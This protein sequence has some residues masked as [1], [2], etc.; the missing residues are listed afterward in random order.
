[1]PH[2]VHFG[3]FDLDLEAAELR[4]N[5][6]KL[7]LPEQQFQ[8]LH[9]LL[10]EEGGV[11]S[12]DEIRK[13]LWPNDTVVEFDRSINAAVMKLRIALGDTGDK[14]RYIETLV[15]RGYRLMV[16]VERAHGTAAERPVAAL[17]VPGPPV[18]GPPVAGPRHSSLVGCKVSHYRVL[19]VLG[20][21]G[22]GLV[23][24]GED[25]KLNRPVALKFLPDEMASD[26]LTVQ[27]FEREA[28]TA[29]SL[30]HPN[31]CTIYEVEE[32]EG[33][34]FI[35][36]ELLEGETLR[37]VIARSRE[38]GRDGLPGLPIPRLLDIAVQI[39]EGLKAAH[40]KG[41]IHRDV[42][43]SN[44]IVTPAGKVKILDFG[45]AKSGA[46]AA[47]DTQGNAWE[48]ARV[49]ASNGLSP[50]P[51]KASIELSLSRTGITMG[52]AGYMSP[53]QVRGD[54]L[55]ART[56]LFSF[57]LILFEMTTGKRAFGGDT[58]TVVQNAIL[59]QQLPP[60]R[61]L[62]PEVPPLLEP[63]IC[64][65]L[66]KDR[67]LRYATAADMLD[68]LN[69]V[70]AKTGP[71]AHANSAITME[72]PRGARRIGLKWASIL[73]AALLATG[74]V[75]LAVQQIPAPSLRISRY[76]QITH[77]GLYKDLCGTDGSR[78]YF[79]QQTPHAI[80][81]VPETGGVI[82]TVPVS[83]P[84]PWLDD[85]SPDG[86]NLLV[87]SQGEGL[88]SMHLLWVVPLLGGPARF[89]ADG[90]SATWSPDSKTVVYSTDSGDLYLIGVDASGDRKLASAGGE[91]RFISWSPDG[92][93]IRF[94][95][96]GRLWD[97]N[98]NGSNLHEVLPGWGGGLSR[99]AVPSRRTAQWGGRW[100]AD[101]R[102]IF[103]SD[104]QIF[105]LDDR[106]RLLRSRAQRPVQLTSG[107]ISWDRAIPSKDGKKIFAS[108]TTRRGE[109]LRFDAKSGHLVPFL[110][111]ISAEFAS[112]SRD[113][114]FVA[115]V[116]YPEGILWRANQDGSS[117]VQLTDS[118]MS[119]RL[120]RWSPDGTA[121]LFVDFTAQGNAAIYTIPS[122]GG[123]APS[124]LMPDDPEPETD[125][126]WS[127]DGRRLVF[128]NSPEGGQHPQSVLRI[129]DM[130]SG[131]VTPIPASKGLFAPR[132]S[133]DGRSIV[134]ET[135]DGMSLKML[136]VATG[137]WSLLHTGPVGYASWS[138]DS[139]Y[140]YSIRWQGDRRVVRI[141]AADGKAE[142]AIDLSDLKDTG[143][144]Q[145]WMGLDPTD[146]PLM[147]REIGTF[148][149][150]AL[151]LDKK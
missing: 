27:R 97:I 137:R 22:M 49:A 143:L 11:V 126:S 117:P 130:T 7:R 109:L 47:I 86:S 83:P 134:A 122:Q 21:G 54:R 99:F 115:Y 56:D 53:E 55:D 14:P 17:P 34:P 75:W 93:T 52:T 98:A 33:Q 136:N 128:S 132:W 1:M 120:P 78:L 90:V 76:E 35:V 91:V 5:G 138:R 104:G 145:S 28:R 37:E 70:K 129:L 32:H 43:P 146:A 8:I 57:G 119:P 80:A 10:D 100:T 13:R 116:S 127:P 66:E 64:K 3:H 87:F 107:P 118:S 142:S 67:N 144:D 60:V 77:D 150:Y 123:R 114:R 51:L 85:V 124:R 73:G 79:T 65:A 62:N 50:V 15:R 133:P 110:G 30:N 141:Q 19:G 125:P 92:A 2:L 113:G 39:A 101:G 44:I 151:T 102:F 81:E 23:Y 103:E 48:P 61:E 68:A 6:R 94:S 4:T 40:Q 29:S 9:M 58:T 12:R 88:R 63:V 140:V 82:S 106:R 69:H 72:S 96:D 149:I 105:I 89:L 59:T 36:M 46:D 45:L 108:G 148:D 112:F 42:K 25:L 111:G 84:I 74:G 139:R 95:K 38:A 121:L 147:M 26:P 131:N 24:K 135:L 20:G 31:I 16:P 71:A 18:P 41:V